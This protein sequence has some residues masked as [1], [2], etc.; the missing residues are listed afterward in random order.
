MPS[1]PIIIGFMPI[2]MGFIAAGFM[3]IMP[4]WPIAPG[5]PCMPCIP[6]FI[7]APPWPREGACAGQMSYARAGCTA[8]RAG[9]Q[10]AAEATQQ[11]HS[12]GAQTQRRVLSAE[13]CWCWVGR[14][15]R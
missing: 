11:V 2:I 5:M 1:A 6:W 10:A 4:P 15:A 8:A 14:N 9:W 13:A 7:V 12:N 3:P